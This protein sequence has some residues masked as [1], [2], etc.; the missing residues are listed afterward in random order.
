MTEV[1]R[2]LELVTFDDQ[3]V[4]RQLEEGEEVADALK[5]PKG[6]IK[7]DLMMEEVREGGLGLTPGGR[8]LAGA[9]GVD[10]AG[11]GEVDLAGGKVDLRGGGGGEEEGPAPVEGVGGSKKGGASLVFRSS[12]LQETT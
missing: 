10:L 12:V 1:W 5:P 9:W 6:Y 7:K 11:G 3:G 2:K 8:D 4:L